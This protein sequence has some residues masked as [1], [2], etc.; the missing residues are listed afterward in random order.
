MEFKK[1]F[2]N[3]SGPER[4]GL[5]TS[6]LGTLFIKYSIVR[7]PYYLVGPKGIA[8]RTSVLGTHFHIIPIDLCSMNFGG[9]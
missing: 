8:N 1:R 6:V 7:V 2:T 4:I 5:S 3:E 9:Q